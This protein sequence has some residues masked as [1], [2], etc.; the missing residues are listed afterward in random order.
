MQVQRVHTIRV[1]VV[2]LTMSSPCPLQKLLSAFVLVLLVLAC[3]QVRVKSILR[4]PPRLCL[5]ISSFVLFFSHGIGLSVRVSSPLF[6]AVVRDVLTATG[7]VGPQ[8]LDDGDRE[9]QR[10]LKATRLDSRDTLAVTRRKPHACFPRVRV[11]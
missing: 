8:G 2:L 3:Y 9:G 7:D 1:R 6:R 11:L 5:R 10:P 4:L